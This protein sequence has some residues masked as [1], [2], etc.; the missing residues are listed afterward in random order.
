M[1]FSVSTTDGVM[2]DALRMEITNTSASPSVTG[3]HDYEYIT[4][5]Q[6]AANDS[7]GLSE[8]QLQNTALPGDANLDGTVDLTDL[9]TVLN[10]FGAATS[11]WL[12]GNFDNAGTVDLT[13]LADVLNNFGTG[14]TGGAV[15]GSVAAP[16]AGTLGLAGT[17]GITLLIRRRVN[18]AITANAQGSNHC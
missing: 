16:E 9:S 17:M 2:Y 1:T 12:D 18:R 3:W 5:S 11:S 6:T 14:S 13:D 15:E 8:A 10:H 7:L 4:T